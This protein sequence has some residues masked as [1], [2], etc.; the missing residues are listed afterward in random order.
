MTVA[1]VDLDQHAGRTT[2][3]CFW[4]CLAAGLSS[5]RWVPDQAL[6]AAISTLLDQ[7]RALD[8]RSLDRARA[9]VIKD[10]P[11][12]S[13]AAALRE[14]FCGGESAVLLRMDM[15]TRIYEAFACL[16]ASGPRRTMATYKAWVERL[17]QN[18]YADE[19]V[20][21]PVAMELNIRTVCVHFHT[22][23][24]STTM[25]CKHVPQHRCHG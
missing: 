18:E 15:L 25:G 12:G 3:A 16:E 10:S 2:G 13:L 17:S 22:A 4:L 23:A 9:S 7:T 5:S 11:L 21:V 8:L 20:I 1:A 19:L 14:F 24:G 6:P